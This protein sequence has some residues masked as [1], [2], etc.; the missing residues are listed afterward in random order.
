MRSFVLV[1]AM[2]VAP[3]MVE[4]VTGWTIEK[5]L[6]NLKDASQSTILIYSNTEDSCRNLSETID[7]RSHATGLP[8]VRFVTCKTPKQISNP[9]ADQPDCVALRIF[10]VR[11]PEPET[12]QWEDYARQWAD[13]LG[14][15]HGET[16]PNFEGPRY[17]MPDNEISW[18]V[19]EIDASRQAMRCPIHPIDRQL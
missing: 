16:N 11:T 6:Q 12:I 2:D 18:T 5:L 9:L 19:H 4:P 8:S 14:M 17:L 10:C 1:P 7:A 13:A 3:G 15:V